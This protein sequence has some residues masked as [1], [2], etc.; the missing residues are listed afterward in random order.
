VLGTQFSLQ[1]E[2]FVVVKPNRADLTQLGAW[3]VDGQRRAVIDS[4]VALGDY[5]VAF[6]KLESKHTHGKIVI[7]VDASASAQPSA[8]KAKRI[9]RR[10]SVTRCRRDDKG[11]MP[12]QLTDWRSDIAAHSVE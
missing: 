11:T 9:Y 2:R 12:I 3:L 10:Q 5:A 6:H 1:Q 8:K 7:D 4:R